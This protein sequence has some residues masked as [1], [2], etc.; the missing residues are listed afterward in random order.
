MS[1]LMNN[2]IEDEGENLTDTE[3]DYD[4]KININN[5]WRNKIFTNLSKFMNT[6]FYKNEKLRLYMIEI[7]YTGSML[8]YW[9]D[10]NDWQNIYNLLE[11]NDKKE[12]KK[13][14]TYYIQK[15]IPNFE[16]TE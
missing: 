10:E 15:K 4:T 1:S 12:M 14:Y 5:I 2:F 6:R 7:G 13:N 9:C 3:D 11:P 8:T 16:F